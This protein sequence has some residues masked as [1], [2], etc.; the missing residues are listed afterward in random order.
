MLF[1]KMFTGAVMAAMTFS[2]FAAVTPR[3]V[4]SQQIADSLTKI[5]QQFQDNQRPAQEITTA[6]ASLIIN[7]QAIPGNYQG[8]H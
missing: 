7:G 1:F 2:V 6:N 3:A 4:T 8:V 5:T